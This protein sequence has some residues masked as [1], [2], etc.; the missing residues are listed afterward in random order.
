ME[1]NN[2]L[3]G[4]EVAIIGM[5]GRFPQSRDL[6][7]FWQ[8]LADG[9]ECISFFS[10]EELLSSGLNLKDIQRPEYVRARGVV[11][12]CEAFDAGFFKFTPREAEITDPQQRLFLEC[13][14]HAFEDAGYVPDAYNGLVGVF[15]GVATS[16][17]FF[18]QIIPTLG[19]GFAFSDTAAMLSNEKD[20]LPTRVS[21]KLNLKGP[22]AAISTGC[23]SSLV[24][25]HIAYKSLLAGECD[26]ALAGGVSIHFPIKS[27]YAFQQGG[28]NSPDGHCRTFDAQAQGSVFGSG[29][30]VVLLKRLEDALNDR[31]SIY[32]VIKGSASNNDGSRR[33]GF[34]APSIEGQSEVIRL[35]RSMAGVDPASI[36][37]IETHGTATPI[38][39]PIEVQAL[40]EAAAG[41]SVP[42]DFCAIGSV[43]TNIGHTAEASGVAG[44]IK[45]ALSLKHRKIPPSLNFTTPNPKL[46]LENSPFFV[47]NK[48]RDWNVE[49]SPL[50][51][52][53][54]S[55]GIGGSNAHV[56]LEEAPKAESTS[57]HRK[58]SLL[59]ISARSAAALEA[60]TDQLSSFLADHPQV[61]LADVAF[62]TQVGRKA[63][64]FRRV[65]V[66]RDIDD[67]AK[68]LK[69]RDRQRVFSSIRPPLESPHAAMMFPGLGDDHSAMAAFLYQAEPVFR[70][71]MDRCFELL[72]QEMAVDFRSVLK[73]DMK[74]DSA[75]NVMPAKSGPDLR[76]MLGR[77]NGSSNG[78]ASHGR[79]DL[80][81][82][83]LFITELALARLWMHWG[84]KPKAL[85]GYSLGEFT[86]ACV[87][88]VFSLQDAI[89]I[90]SARARLIQPLPPGAMLAV[91]LPEKE[92]KELAG[93]E[94]GI[95][96][97]NGPSFTVLSGPVEKIEAL[98]TRL[99]SDGV[100][101]RRLQ[102]NHALHSQ[103]MAAISEGFIK[104]LEQFPA[105][106]P[107][108]PYISNV[109]GDWI[110]PEEACSPEYWSRHLCGTVRFGDGIEKLRQAG[111]RVFLE[112][113]PGQTLCSLL[114]QHPACR[115]GEPVVAL[116]SL[117]SVYDTMDDSG[118]LLSSFGRLWLEGW[119]P[120]WQ[121]FH[122]DDLRSRV[123][124]PAY[125][126]ERKVYRVQP[127]GAQPGFVVPAMAPERAALQEKPASPASE[128]SVQQS[129]AARDAAGADEPVALPET[130]FQKKIA[131]VWYELLGI[132]QIGI[133]DN[134]FRLGGDSLLGTR[135]ISRLSG[136]F[137]VEL[138]LRQLM[139]NPTISSLSETIETL[140]LQKLEEIS[141]EE[142]ANLA[143]NLG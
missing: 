143:K 12:D 119:V 33:V 106:A 113:G 111:T 60:S 94:L 26:M 83:S 127:T 46:G 1:Q 88:G 32:A 14:W 53:V 89:K 93:D 120:D 61:N 47:N 7:Q 68:T 50:R 109:T 101:T 3:T 36:T 138:P 140:L 58:F 66:C 134:F 73:L 67:A 48:L 80:A 104:I 70:A 39:D 37:Y 135:L 34:T 141:D 105:H 8:N 100:D 133:H 51:A 10:D 4:L 142:A 137:P 74:A 112:V 125:P 63:F 114:L 86:A 25:T 122:K 30:G 31:D 52:G 139:E 95:A 43:K 23:S 22:S 78:A 77:S 42:Q 79:T 102:T 57:S 6:R 38:G 97:V 28:V 17:Y 65:L 54:S 9:R 5:A 121:S 15:A 62:T 99:K 75:D 132:E 108:I 118:V 64:D 131:E 29:I 129:M 18:Y 116:Q 85:I 92:V 11:E 115:S 117:S 126:F 45:T 76:R 90:V 136:I 124:L 24:A 2:N 40:V 16:T 71:E 19:S 98:Q 21:Y 69:T 81:Q 103:S 59:T 35:A 20:F 96:A 110:K 56:V 91:P 107:T 87:A 44:L 123:S 82:V 41:H 13:A 27:G 128:A 72:K 84:L 49:G 55:F 130:E